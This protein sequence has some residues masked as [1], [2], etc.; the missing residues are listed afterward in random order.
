[1]KARLTKK[2]INQKK[3]QAA[4]Y[5]GI[6]YSAVRDDFT[7]RLRI[8]T[9]L[10]GKP[11]YFLPI[12]RY[13]DFGRAVKCLEN[14]KELAEKDLKRKQKVSFETLK[15]FFEDKILQIR[16][17][18]KENPKSDVALTANASIAAAQ[19]RVTILKKIEKYAPTLYTK[20]L[21]NIK[22]GELQNVY[23]FMLKADD[24]TVAPKTLYDNICRVKS[25][26][27]G[28]DI[29]V[30]RILLKAGIN[31]D[32]E[33]FKIVKVKNRMEKDINPEEKKKGR[34]FS[35]NE[36]H[37][38]FR[39]ALKM[40]DEE[41]SEKA[42]KV[43]LAILLEII[44]G[45]RI[46]ELLNVSKN[47]IK[48]NDIFGMYIVIHRQRNRVTGGE[49]IAKTEQSNRVLP[50]CGYVY[51]EIMSHVK[52][53]Q[54]NDDDKILFSNQNKKNRG[55]SDG[56]IG[57]CVKEVEKAA[58]ISHV[59]G[60]TNHVQRN[61]LI[62]F[63]EGVLRVDQGTVRY[64][65]GHT[66]SGDAHEGYFSDDNESILTLRSKYFRAA[67]YT[68]IMTILNNYDIETANNLYVS[69]LAREKFTDPHKD[70]QWRLAGA[71]EF[72]EI[73]KLLTE[74]K[75]FDD[76]STIMDFT[77]SGILLFNFDVRFFAYQEWRYQ[78]NNAY[79]NANRAIR[80]KYASFDEYIKDK[81]SDFGDWYEKYKVLNNITEEVP[82]ED[83]R[84]FDELNEDMIAETFSE[85]I[86]ESAGEQEEQLKYYYSDEM[87]EYRAN[88][89][90]E[91]FF[92]DM[93]DKAN[94][95]IKDDFIKWHNDN[96]I[97]SIRIIDEGKN[98][99]ELEERIKKRLKNQ[100]N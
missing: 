27:N 35:T 100:K 4:Q 39:Q 76:V 9:D 73:Y 98:N 21:E 36:L 69:T 37:S 40:R 94:P 44:S 32:A 22:R 10:M 95:T 86:D 19:A 84:T 42:D 62:T 61:D 72:E 45:A 90:E 77:D 31:I 96:Y 1:M 97:N 34:D 71:E 2:E 58:G 83:N 87:A 12:R 16:K 3:Q 20:P 66:K 8:G 54:L 82:F 46:N 24:L 57:K 67:Q 43:F 47:K 74:G 38:I 30:N 15:L 7:V 70:F 29:D 25:M 89:S 26:F 49:G 91:D 99:K 68:Y 23:E 63:F 17:Y 78:Q 59:K 6:S 56:Y 80:I 75:T 50:I 48:Y 92:A 85:M 64:F 5:K 13:N 33:T 52:K 55:L 11:I 18:A 51:N 93:H 28:N 14:Y 60:R 65:T 79:K 53:Y 81:F 41:K 88:N